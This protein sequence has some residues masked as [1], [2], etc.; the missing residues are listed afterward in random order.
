MFRKLNYKINQQVKNKVFTHT[1]TNAC[2]FAYVKMH[3]CVCV[4]VYVG[5]RTS[6]LYLCMCMFNLVIMS[7]RRPNS[8]LAVIN[9]SS[10]QLFPFLY[11]NICPF[12]PLNA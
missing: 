3:M 5:A 11:A 10:L 2:V 8:L 6:Y 9:Y 4:C 1:Y 12:P 7:L